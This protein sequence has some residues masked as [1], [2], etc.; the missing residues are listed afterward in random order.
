MLILFAF[1]IITISMQAQ[2]SRS[3]DRQTGLILQRIERGS[4]TFHNSLRV[5]L[6]QR[7]GDQTSSQNNI[8]A[9]QAN[10]ENAT[11]QFREQLTARHADV[12]DVLNVLQKAA[13]VNSFMSR[14]RLNAR[15]QND[16][17]SI[18]TDLNSL[19]NAYGVSW[20]WAADTLPPVNASRARLSNN[21]LS[22]LIQR[23][24]TGGDTFRSSLTD[25]FGQS[26]FDRT[27]REG[28]MNRVVRGF[29]SATEQLSNEF[30]AGR[31]VIK[32][33]QVTLARAIPIDSFM[34]SN[35]LTNRAQNDWS[36]VR[37]DLNTLAAA[38]NIAETAEISNEAPAMQASNNRLSGTF[39]LDSSRSD[40]PRDLAE[41]ATRNLPE[42]ERV[43]V[44]SQI[45]SRLDSPQ[46][47]AIDRQGS[48]VTIASSLAPQTT[49]EADAR[50]RQ[51]QLGNDRSTRVTATLSGEQLVVSSNGYKENDF[52]V[53]FDATGNNGGLR[54]R[55]QIFSDR[56]TQPV[57]IDSVYDR[58]SDVADW[59]VF[60]L[61]GLGGNTTMS[62]GEFMVRDGERVVAVLNNDLTTKNAK[63]GDRFTMTVRQPGEYEGAVIEGTVASI[64]QGGRLSGR[65]GMTLNFD[66]IRPRN[67]SSYRFAG[68]LESIRMLSGD[69]VKV[70]NE[71]SAQGDNQTTQTIQRGGIGTAIGAIVGVIAGGAKGAV[72]GG[73]IGATAGAGSVYVQGKDNLELPTGTELTIRASAPRR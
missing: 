43:D 62:N 19:A 72:I 53:T 23:I 5:A 55:R 47:L 32:F 13:R 20:Q 18:R 38:Y 26:P 59:S 39:R 42:R 56:L 35:P 31:S 28:D 27:S 68:T 58:T 17:S 40:N 9:L 21:E 49:F 37:R 67:G 51:E 57:V 44:Y 14:N 64:D 69:S 45:M 54:V 1:S 8:N 11:T 63:Q 29:K 4:V 73:I 15:V 7:R 25:A 36:I 48:T 52:N 65:S 6:V 22:Q 30:D 61:S 41:R 16:W 2:S 66:T 50:E 34:R 46:M 24:D 70:D 12:A 10:F 3:T 71:G 33:V 60:D